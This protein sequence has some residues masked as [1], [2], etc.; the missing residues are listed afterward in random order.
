MDTKTAVVEKKS[1]LLE[2]EQLLR[3]PAPA[4]LVP[5]PIDVRVPDP[6]SRQTPAVG[7][8]TTRPDGRLHGLVDLADEAQLD[9]A[10]M[11]LGIDDGF[12]RGSDLG[13]GCHGVVPQSGRPIS[14]SSPS[15]RTG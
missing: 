6:A 2:A 15:T 1:T 3:A 8:R 4:P 7:Q 10:E 13:F 11:D 9:D 12:Q 14:T 5:F